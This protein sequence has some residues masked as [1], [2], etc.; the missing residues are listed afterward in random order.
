MKKQLFALLGLGLLF[1]TASAY[2]Q[3]AAL[4]ANIP[5]N[6][7]ATGKSLPAG[8]YTIQSLS[9]SER[10]LVIRGPE[11]SAH[12]VMAN[13]CESAKPSDK[14]KLVFH[15]YGD[16]YFLSQIWTA[17]NSSGAEL[18]QSRREAEVAM[19]FPLQE[20]ILIASR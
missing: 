13:A 3:T 7:V 16:R 2:A 15:R 5:F 1:A 19:D 4:K 18:P 9:T 14:T 6:F 10:V 20:V 12:M 11:K 8:E 17:G